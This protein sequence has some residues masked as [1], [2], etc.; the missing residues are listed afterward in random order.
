[1]THQDQSTALEGLVQLLADHGFD[2]MAE[3]I[4]ILMNEAMKLERTEVLGAAP[5]E[6]STS[7]R[8]YANGFKPKTVNS[9]LGRLELRIPQTR[10]VEFYPSALERGERSER[11]L[12]LAVAEMYV[13]GVST[14]KVAEITEELCGLDVSSSQ[15]SRAAQLL[16]EELAAWRERPLEQVPYLILDARYEKVRHGGSVRDCAV[17]LA[18]GILPDGKRSVLGVS[19]SLS[20]AEVHWREFLSS[21]CERGLH[22]VE[23]IVSDDHAGL[24]QAR[25]ACFPGVL[26]QRCQFHLQQNALHY[27]PKIAMRKEVAADL[28]TIFDAPDRQEADRRMR[29]VMKK[30]AKS[31]PDLVTWIEDNVPEGLAVMELPA[32]LRRRLRTSNMLER[33]NQEIKR[34]TRVATLFPNEASLLR[35]VSAV[36][37]EISEEWETGKVY[38]RIPDETTNKN[39]RRG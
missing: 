22:G 12:K 4:T 17:L 18:V 39:R 25:K 7:R 19:V 10:G 3:A 38:L 34:R 2:G 31:A 33:L 5:Y 1:M 20:E 8:G 9:R 26:W 23:F 37:I 36:L 21:L 32:S 15:V 14:R 27:V 35:L 29:Q 11:A 16:D 28:R 13:Q 6:R 24:K 30:Y